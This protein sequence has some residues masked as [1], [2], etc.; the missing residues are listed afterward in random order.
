MP[1]LPPDAARKRTATDTV[2]SQALHA[3]KRARTTFREASRE[4]RAAGRDGDR[5][6]MRQF[7]EAKRRLFQTAADCSRTLREAVEESRRMGG[8]AAP[9]RE[10][11][12]MREGFIY[13]SLDAGVDLICC[14]M[15]HHRDWTYEKIALSRARS[16]SL[17]APT[18][19]NSVFTSP[20]VNFCD[21][22]AHKLASDW[23]TKVGHDCS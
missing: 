16:I 20:V 12:A 4:S 14:C 8:E 5:A 15:K 7:E 6:F 18:G 1:Q 2:A 3:P 9:V 19:C 11:P 23:K 21:V 17:W 22:R 13:T 10:A